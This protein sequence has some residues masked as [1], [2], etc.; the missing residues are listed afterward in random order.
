[1]Q[2]KKNFTAGPDDTKVLPAQDFQTIE[3]AKI[4]QDSLKSVTDVVMAYADAHNVSFSKAATHLIKPA[5]DS[6]A[7][8]VVDVLERNGIALTSG[9]AHQSTPTQRVFD[10]AALS[11]WG[12][13]YVQNCFF[14]QIHDAAFFRI[15]T[16]SVGFAA[17]AGGAGRGALPT[18][19]N[20]F[21]PPTAIPVMPEKI[22]YQDLEIADIIGS[23]QEISGSRATLPKVTE[24]KNWKLTNIGEFADIPT[25]RFSVGENLTEL[26]KAGY[27]HEV[28]YELLRSPG[29]TMEGLALFAMW[30]AFNATRDIV[31]EG[32][33]L[34]FNSARTGKTG[35]TTLDRKS[36][37][38]MLAQRK[39]GTQ[40]SLAV[41]TLDAFVEYASVDWTMNSNN[42][43]PLTYDTMGATRTFLDSP[44]GRQIIAYRDDTEVAALGGA[45]EKLGLMD[46]RFVLEYFFERNSNIE[47]QDINRAQQYVSFF[48]TFS[49]TFAKMVMS[50]EARYVAE[51]AA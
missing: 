11:A 35:A 31:N 48:R 41:G 1:M 51:L 12:I 30:L 36:A 6:D 45:T 49:Y 19:G 2:N 13:E 9:M 27:G 20:A 47:E 32:L 33:Q 7:D 28:S 34:G 4:G 39:K 25:W 44:L 24:P 15:G 5:E 18:E 50:D 26:S 38:K 23:R 37:I 3:A 42:P 40:F 46:T 8:I 10:N 29:Q 17:N 14:Y 21:N 43:A 22:L 16:H